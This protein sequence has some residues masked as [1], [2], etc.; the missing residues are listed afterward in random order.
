M[1]SQS[2]ADED[3]SSPLLRPDSD[4]ETE[5]DDGDSH[6]SSATIVVVLSTLVAV[7][8]SYVVG[9]ANGFSSPALSGILDDLGLSLAQVIL[10]LPT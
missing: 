9:C 10:Y 2:I 5:A 7:L 1:E 4:I 8:G 6:G 3:G